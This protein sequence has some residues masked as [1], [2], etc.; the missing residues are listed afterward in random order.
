MAPEGKLLQAV[1]ALFMYTLYRACTPSSLTL[2][3]LTHVY[4]SCVYIFTHAYTM[5]RAVAMAYN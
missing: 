3:L 5:I 4:Y 1:S 2:A